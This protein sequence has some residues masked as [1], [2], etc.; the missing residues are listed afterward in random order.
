MNIRNVFLCVVSFLL[1]IYTNKWNSIINMR[2]AHMHDNQ[3]TIRT[4]IYDDDDDTR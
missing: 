3:N 4:C 2:D 1:F